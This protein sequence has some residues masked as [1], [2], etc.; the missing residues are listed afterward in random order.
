[1]P[2][3]KNGTPTYTTATLPASL[4][5]GVSVVVDGVVLSK[6]VNSLFGDGMPSSR[7]ISFVRGASDAAGIVKDSSGMGNGLYVSPTATEATALGTPGKLVVEAGTG[8]GFN[9]FDKAKTNFDITTDSFIFSAT[10][11]IAVAP[12]AN[13]SLFGNADASSSQG[14]YLSV[15]ATSGKVKPIFNTSNGV[16]SST[17]DTNAVLA[18]GTDKT[19][20]CAW[21]AK[22]RLFHFWMDGELTD[23]RFVGALAG[24]CTPSR[25]FSL[26][27]AADTGL[28]ASTSTAGTFKNIHFL[29]FADSAL[30]VNIGYIAKRLMQVPDSHLQDNIF[31]M[32]NKKIQIIL[33]ACQSNELGLGET[34]DRTSLW[35]VPHKDGI[36]PTAAGL[37]TGSAWPRLAELA[38]ARGVSL[39]IYNSARAGSSILQN[40]CGICRQWSSGMLAGKGLWLLSGGGLWQMTSGSIGAF[41]ASTVAP[42]GA[43]TT[44]GADGITWT[45]IGVPTAIDVDGHVYTHTEAS[46]FDPCSLFA[47]ALAGIT[48][49]QT[50]DERYALLQIGQTDAAHTNVTV[51]NFADGLTNAANYWKSKGC[52]VL[53]G[54]TV[55]M[56]SVDARYQSTIIP[57]RQQVLSAFADDPDVLEGADLYTYFN[58]ASI[59][60]A[61]VQRSPVASLM[62]YGSGDTLG[63]VHLNCAGQLGAADAHFAQ[64]K[65]LGIL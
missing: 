55:C 64:M 34:V 58:G 56:P 18:T 54:M 41:T 21:D 19:F 52:K 27:M 17:T 26:G 53:I 4:P 42:T 33:G 13:Y 36:W 60:S 32:P 37:T 8:K 12:A 63:S 49:N 48:A 45:Y 30:P 50:F 2:R 25:Y 22:L 1:M 62:N 10:V 39:S 31:R 20:V 23:S 44:T 35:G 29:R 46:R 16:F 28:G 15:R 59:P 43:T 57:A 5:A 47:T 61:T 7:Y 9:F 3:Y 38:G 51:Q 14:F 11:N 24:T 65:N 6:G 40:W